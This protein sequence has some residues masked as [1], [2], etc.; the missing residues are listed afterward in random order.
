MQLTNNFSFSFGGEYKYDWGEFENRGS[1]SASTKGNVYNQGI[2]SNIGFKPYEN[3]TISLYGRSDQHKT[4]G[5]N[6]TRKI[7]ITQF[8]DKFKVGF[9]HSTGLRNPSLYELYG[10]DNF[11]YSGNSNLNPEKSESNEIL[12]EYKISDNF[13][14]SLTAFKSNIFDL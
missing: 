4:T 14:V 8:I 6:N 5:L 2:Y 9:T 7:N 3:T 11:G 13:L 1:Y 10:T 12:G